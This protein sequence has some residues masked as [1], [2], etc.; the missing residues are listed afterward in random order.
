MTQT[1]NKIFHRNTPRS[2]RIYIFELTFHFRTQRFLW[3]V[4][5]SRLF[6]RRLHADA[7]QNVRHRNLRFLLPEQAP[8]FFR[9]GWRR[10]IS[11]GK[12]LMRAVWLPIF[13]CDRSASCLNGWLSCTMEM[14][15][16]RVEAIADTRW[17]GKAHWNGLCRVIGQT[18]AW[19]SRVT[20]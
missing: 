15:L 1:T 8:K 13:S 11:N 3:H 10:M 9:I 2:I 17:F 6:M 20:W 16:H 14:R 7:M 12:H 5:S 4:V 19:R 18:W